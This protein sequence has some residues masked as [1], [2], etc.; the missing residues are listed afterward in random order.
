MNRITSRVG[1]GRVRRNRATNTWVGDHVG[2]RLRQLE[3][4]SV[5]DYVVSEFTSC[6]S[7]RCVGVH[8]QSRNSHSESELTF[9]VGVNVQ[10]RSSRSESE[11]RSESQ[12]SHIYVGVMLQLRRSHVAVTS[13][14]SKLSCWSHIAMYITDYRLSQNL[15]T[16]IVQQSLLDCWSSCWGLC[17]LHISGQTFASFNGGGIWRW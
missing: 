1:G 15:L 6:R 11:S 9:R 16:A 8:I 14:T 17:Y 7:L 4:T 3:I 13:E 12:S 10:S 2:W 5:G